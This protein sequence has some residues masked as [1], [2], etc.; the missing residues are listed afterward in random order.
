MA[1]IV[2]LVLLVEAVVHLLTETSTMAEHTSF[3]LFVVTAK[4]SR[5]FLTLL[6]IALLWW[7]LATLLRPTCGI[8][9]SEISG[10]FMGV[11]LVVDEVPALC[12]VRAEILDN[13]TAQAECYV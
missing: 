1:T 2:F 7:I 3:T 11:L 4:P 13:R 5:T 8:W 9:E 10:G 6:K 12:K